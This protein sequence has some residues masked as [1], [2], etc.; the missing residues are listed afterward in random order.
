MDSKAPRKIT[1]TVVERL[2]IPESGY[3][4]TRD[5]ELR[6]FGVRVTANGAKSFIL[7]RRVKGRVK[8]FTVGRYGP[9]FSVEKARKKAEKIGGKIADGQD[10]AEERRRKEAE[11]VTL[12]KAIAAY[13]E[14]RNLKPRTLADVDEAM[15]SLES[16][17]DRRL[18]DITAEKVLKRHREL[19]KASPA[20]A[21]LTMRYLRAIWN[22]ARA[23]YTSP[24][25]EPILNGNPVTALS[26]LRAW[27]EVGRRK[28]VIRKEQLRPWLNAVLGLQGP[29]SRDLFLVLVLTGLR[30]SEA[31]G[32]T[33]D[34]VNLT[35][36]AVTITDAKGNP[37]EISP[38]SLLVTDTKAKRNHMLPLGK[39]L[40]DLLKARRKAVPKSCP[41]V[42]ADAEGNRFHDP[43]SS[44][45]AVIQ[46]SG[47][48]FCPH[49]LRRT[50]ATIA[51]SLDLSA[52]AVKRLLNHA[53]NADV[54]AGY[55]VGDTD[56]DRKSVV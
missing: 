37:E 10:P 26:A 2:P 5:T 28:T 47:V 44:I 11:N 34:R 8:R 7:E 55:I 25:G 52:Y 3:T 29:E 54:T 4:I 23:R 19:S 53:T 40:L 12:A 16:W 20:R 38:H 15:K 56:R 45:R 35:G 32:L 6:G 9:D 14:T 43:R 30:K 46:R 39:Y 42:F 21:N 49:D 51:E 31:L 13:K 1:K 24:S 36:E 22:F 17:K 33:W 18:V 41:W 27:N 50:F 48:P